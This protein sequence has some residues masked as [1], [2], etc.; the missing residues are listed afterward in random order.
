M[1]QFHCNSDFASFTR[2]VLCIR[3][4]SLLL[5]FYISSVSL[6]RLAVVVYFFYQGILQRDAMGA[7]ARCTRNNA[8]G[9]PGTRSS[10]PKLQAASYI[11][12]YHPNKSGIP[13]TND[14]K[15]YLH[16]I[17]PKSWQLL[18]HTYSIYLKYHVSK[19]LQ[20]SSL[21]TAES[22]R[23][24]TCLGSGAANATGR[25]TAGFHHFRCLH[26]VTGKDS[27]LDICP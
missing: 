15:W 10:E 5:G 8:D 16:D 20:Y 27:S 11:V 1:I 21:S 14:Y 9:A 4:Y 3:G 25:A 7:P 23:M 26:P 22:K 13:I 6:H 18:H 17:M 2:R 19:E 24:A 12:L